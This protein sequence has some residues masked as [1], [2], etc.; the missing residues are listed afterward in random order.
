MKNTIDY[1]S[2][3]NQRIKGEFVKRSR[4]NDEAGCER[5]QDVEK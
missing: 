2:V 1:D 5:K 3:E 4:M